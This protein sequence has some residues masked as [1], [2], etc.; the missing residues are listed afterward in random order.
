MSLLSS[1][2]PVRGEVKVELRSFPQQPEKGSRSVR[3][4]EKPVVQREKRERTE[5]E[6]VRRGTKKRILT[7]GK[8]T[9]QYAAR[10]ER[11]DKGKKRK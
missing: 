7:P 1:Y 5:A 9:R 2:V 10:A 11:S 8:R 4:K 3:R 6:T